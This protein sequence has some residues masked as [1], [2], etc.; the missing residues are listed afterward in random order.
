MSK[1]SRRTLVTSAA[2]LPALAVPALAS[3]TM[4]AN[5][6]F[7]L[8]QMGAKLKILIGEYL[9]LEERENRRHAAWEAACVAAGLPDKP[10][11][12]SDDNYR[13]Y[14]AKRSS[15]RAYSAEDEEDPENPDG[16]VALQNKITDR[17]YPLVDKILSCKAHTLAGLAVQA[18]AIS[19]HHNESAAVEEGTHAEHREFIE[20][21]CAF[22]NYKPM[23][24]RPLAF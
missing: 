5:P 3:D 16:W 13:A 17:L 12:L 21:V 23:L 22:L 14:Q 8:L 10:G 11:R 2:T 19:C 1:L 4:A 6:D 9:A 24:T 18:E 15:L 7:K 20:A